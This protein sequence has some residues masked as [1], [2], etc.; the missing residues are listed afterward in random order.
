M[1]EASPP[2]GRNRALDRDQDILIHPWVLDKANDGGLRHRVI[3]IALRPPNT[4][5][6]EADRD[7]VMHSETRNELRE[8]CVLVHRPRT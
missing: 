4:F 1:I 6:R 8:A 2:S 7:P 5:Q 3:R